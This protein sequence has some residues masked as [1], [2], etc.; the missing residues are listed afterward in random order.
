MMMRMTVLVHTTIV[1]Y[2]MRDNSSC[3]GCMDE[4]AC[5]YDASATIQAVEYSDSGS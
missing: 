2:A 1:E 4:S 3:T 5:D